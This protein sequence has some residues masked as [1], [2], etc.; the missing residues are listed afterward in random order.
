[1]RQLAAVLVLCALSISGCSISSPVKTTGPESFSMLE[2]DQV[3]RGWALEF[4]PH[5]H[6]L[7]VTQITGELRLRNMVSGSWIDVEGVPEVLVEGQ[8]GLGDFIVGPQY[9]GE[10]HRTVFLSWVEAGPSDTAGAVVGRANLIVAPDAAT[11]KLENLERIWEQKPKAT[12][13]G[14]YAHRLATSPDGQYLFITSGDR[15]KS[16]L[17]QD[18]NGTLGKIIRLTIDGQVPD[19]NPITH[20]G[21]I[22]KQ[23][24]TSGHRNVLGIAFA[25]DGRLWAAEMGPQGGDEFN[26][27]EPGLNYGWPKVSNGSHYSGKDIP[28]HS[29]SDGYAAPVEYWTPSISPGNLI[30][31]RGDR[32]EGWTGDAILGALSGQA[33]VRVDLDGAISKGTQQWAMGARIRAVEECP[34]GYIWLLEDGPDGRLMKLTPST[35]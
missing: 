5:S 14:H 31:Y 26:L 12:G 16:E 9:D 28:D 30:I 1:M 3:D 21:E 10:R 20:D 34:D 18:V 15:Q 19:D 35:S 6:L 13:R 11:A 23:I 2:I 33:L 29:R 24:W 7:A 8:G 27:I 17:A 25:P 32:F 4:L 22:A